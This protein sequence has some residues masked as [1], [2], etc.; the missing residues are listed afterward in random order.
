MCVGKLSNLFM[1]SMALI[2]ALPA[3]SSDLEIRSVRSRL[4]GHFDG[5]LPTLHVD[6]DLESRSSQVI[7][8]PTGWLVVRSAAV[9]HTRELTT[10]IDSVEPGH[11]VSVSRTLQAEHQWTQGHPTLEF[12]LRDFKVNESLDVFRTRLDGGSRLMEAVVAA[13]LGASSDWCSW[14]KG[15]DALDSAKRRIQRASDH[16]M[17]QAEGFLRIAMLIGIRRCTDSNVSELSIEGTTRR[18]LEEVLQ[19]LVTDVQANSRGS[20]LAQALPDGT[21]TLDDLLQ[22]PLPELTV[23]AREV[24]LAPVEP[25]PAQNRAGDGTRKTVTAVG[26]GACMLLVMWWRRRRTT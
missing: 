18:A 20:P 6:I 14:W 24:K 5:R 8:K 21:Q 16:F 1:A 13:S 4:D 10:L 2:W 12:E 22:R 26:I 15:P 11:R 17:P 9:E 7:W 25:E 19:V 3:A 23:S